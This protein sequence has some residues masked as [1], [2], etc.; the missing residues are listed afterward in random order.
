MWRHDETWQ[1]AF[2]DNGNKSEIGSEGVVVKLLRPCSLRV[3]AFV[4]AL[5]FC[6][7]N[8]LRKELCGHRKSVLYGP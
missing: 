6:V 3:T 7:I 4:T 2:S 5:I 1:F 8:F